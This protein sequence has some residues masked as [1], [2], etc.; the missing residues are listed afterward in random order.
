MTEAADS[1]VQKMANATKDPIVVLHKFN[2]LRTRDPNSLVLVVEGDDDPVFYSVAANR[3]GLEVPF[4][5]L[6]A[7]GKDLVLGFRELLKNSVEAKRGAG[8]AFAVDRDF[9]DLK[10]YA[11]GPDLYCTPTYSIENIICSPNAFRHLLYHEFKLH[12]PDLLGD[13]E[14]LAM[15]YEKIQGEFAAET[16]DLNLLIFFGRTRS[17]ECCGASIRDIDDT[18][19]RLFSIDASSLAV[20]CH[21]R[22]D[23]A[24]QIV[25]FSREVRL[26]DASVVEST[27]SELEPFARWRGKFWLALLRRLLSVLQEDRNSTSP[28]HFSRGRGKVRLSPASD[29]IFR[30]LGSACEIP[31]CMRLFF[32]QLQE[33]ALR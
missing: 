17:L 3:C 21:F 14:R 22:G 20:V 4:L 1:R 8:V 23:A 29:S 19:A 33:H 7:G 26:A 30:I 24:T 32:A 27:F 5:S 15:A 18:P 2:K 6:V 31:P 28:R 11:P 9:D 12:D 13:V 16:R 10:G 25:R